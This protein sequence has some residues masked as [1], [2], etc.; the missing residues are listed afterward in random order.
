[1]KEMWEDRFSKEEFVYGTEPNQFYKGEIDKL[2]PGKAL[3]IGEGEGRNSVYAAKLGWQVDAT[4]WSENARKKALEW[5]K[6]NNV[7]INYENGS[8]EELHIKE[9]EYDLVVFI[10]IHVYPEL[11]ENLHSQAV[12]SLKPGGRIILEAYDKDQLKYKSGGPKNP[13]LLYSLEDIYTDFNELEIDTFSKDVI[14]LKESRF[15]EGDA[16]VIRYVGHKSA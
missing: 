13:D 1:M 2:Q 4:D 3:F 15:H 14:Y 5:A 10:F 11:R 16:S 12:K 9:N 6:T 8:F 7:G